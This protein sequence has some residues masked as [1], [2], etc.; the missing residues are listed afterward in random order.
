RLGATIG[1]VRERD[2]V[3]GV[4]P[5]PQV[6]IVIEFQIGFGLIVGF[7][8]GSRVIAV[9]GLPPTAL[10]V[11]EIQVRVVEKHIFGDLHLG[12]E[13]ELDLGILDVRNAAISVLEGS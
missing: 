12:A 1:L 11:G 3:G 6:V 5:A 9:V 13:L 7:T 2:T 4:G 8:E 10:S